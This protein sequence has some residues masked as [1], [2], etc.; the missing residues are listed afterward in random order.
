[1]GGGAK[2]AVG[3]RG[4][5]GWGGGGGNGFSTLF[6]H[7]TVSHS[8]N[9][10][11]PKGDETFHAEGHKNSPVLS[12]LKMTPNWT[13]TA[14]PEC[15]AKFSAA[16]QLGSLPMGTL[17]FRAP[18]PPPQPRQGSN[19]EVAGKMRTHGAWWQ[20]RHPRRFKD[21]VGHNGAHWGRWIP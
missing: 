5:G 1:M 11:S 7:L 16:Q 3:S 17:R 14:C 13:R 12:V 6:I 4:R 9:L 21:T 10:E 8:E 19:V 20:N 2:G 18:P 15:P